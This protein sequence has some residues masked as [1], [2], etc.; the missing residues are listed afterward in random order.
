VVGRAVQRLRDVLEPFR[1]SVDIAPETP[2][3]WLDSVLMEQV[4]VNVLDNAAKY[5]PANGLIVIQAGPLG[6]LLELRVEDDGPGIPPS[7]RELVFDIFY[8]VKARDSRTAGTG[9]GLSICRGLIEAHGGTITAEEG[10]GQRGTAIVVRLPLSPSP[11]LD[12]DDGAAEPV[13]TEE[14]EQ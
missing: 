5:S 7:E 1:V 8:R 14:D 3:L 11:H 2:L 6:G 9:L 4:L 12:A 10:R 13:A